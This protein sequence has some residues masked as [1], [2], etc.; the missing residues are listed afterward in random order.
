MQTALHENENGGPLRDRRDEVYLGLVFLVNA[1][2]NKG[3]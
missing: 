3:R 2:S 1:L